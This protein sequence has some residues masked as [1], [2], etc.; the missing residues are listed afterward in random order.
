[1]MYCDHSV[2]LMRSSQT[3]LNYVLPTQETPKCG[4]NATHMPSVTGQPHAVA[5]RRGRR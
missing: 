3:P 2:G 4:V 5:I 1:M